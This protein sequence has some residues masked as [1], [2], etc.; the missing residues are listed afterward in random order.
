MLFNS[1][2]FI[3]NFLPAVVLAYYLCLFFGW[4]KIALFVLSIAS[5]YF[6]GYTN[7][8]NYILILTSISFNFFIATLM[9]SRL[10]TGFLAVVGVVGNLLLLGHFKYYYFVASNINVAFGTNISA[11]DVVLPIG[12][13]F[14]TFQQIAF[15]MDSHKYGRQEKNFLNYSLFVMFF[16]QLIAGPIVHHREVLPQFSSVRWGTLVENLSV[17]TTIFVIG[18]FKK[19]VLADS[20]AP[21]STQIFDA[22]AFQG[23]V[24][25][26]YEA[27]LAA[28]AY[29]FQIYFDFSAYSDMAIGLGRMFGITL[30]INFNSPYKA[31]SIGDFWRRWHITLSRF[32]RQ[33]LYF[34]LGGNRLGSARTYSNVLLT[35]VIGGIWHGAGWTFIVW[36]G[37]HGL[38]MALE[39]AG[40]TFFSFRIPAVISR[41]LTFTFVLVAWVPFRAEDMTVTAKLYSSMA[42]YGS[43]VG[44]TADTQAGFILALGLLGICWLLPNTQQLVGEHD[45][46]HIHYGDRPS[47]KIAWQPSMLMAI[48][49]AFLFTV[50]VLKLNDFSEFIYFKF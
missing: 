38:A 14:F 46:S 34:P 45:G 27:W 5:L 1:V 37:M 8:S 47:V 43:G 3:F 17:G 13:S 31:T 26:T 48:W 30:P 22:V 32:L 9:A 10:K 6:Y 4:Q 44:L 15:I 50:C 21:Y 33:Y 41:L 28:L 40:K 12:I 20:I 49:M 23:H 42:G 11:P 35:M 19:V 18:L 29:N 36:G 7:T 39:R 25:S 24:P 2:V 16:P